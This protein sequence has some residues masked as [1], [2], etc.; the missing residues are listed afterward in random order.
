MVCNIYYNLC[1]NDVLLR[2]QYENQ[3]QQFSWFSGLLEHV[4][5]GAVCPI[6][7]FLD[8]FNHRGRARGGHVSAPQVY[9]SG[10][11]K[12]LAVA[13]TA[14]VTGLDLFCRLGRMG[15][16]SSPKLGALGIG[17]HIGLFGLCRDRAANYTGV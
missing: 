4:G 6:A 14:A 9:S 17:H 13:I 7:Q 11:N 15:G 1:L 8:Y 16:F 3:G 10:A 5:A 12:T 2:Q